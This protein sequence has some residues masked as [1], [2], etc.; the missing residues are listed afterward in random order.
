[1]VCRWSGDGLTVLVVLVLVARD[2][3]RAQ[4]RP[5]SRRGLRDNVYRQ[6]VDQKAGGYGQLTIAVRIVSHGGGVGRVW[7]GGCVCMCVCGCCQR[8]R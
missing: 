1:M 5:T 8:A 6:R 7:C 2:P 4:A 3:L